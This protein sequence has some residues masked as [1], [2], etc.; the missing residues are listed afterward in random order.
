MLLYKLTNRVTGQSYIGVTGRPLAERLSNHRTFAAKGMN[1]PLAIA[2][3]KHGWQ[4]FEVSELGRA[5]SRDEVME[6]EKAAIV[7]YK[8]LA[9]NGYN[10][11][12]GGHGSPGP[13]SEATREKQRVSH[14]GQK[15]WIT[16]KRHSDESR[17]KMSASRKGNGWNARAITYEGVTYPS[18][19]ALCA[20]T[21]LTVGQVKARLF[22]GTA[23]H[24]APSKLVKGFGTWNK[25]KT[26]SPEA[27]QK[28]SAARKGR[29]TWNT[30][31]IEVDGVAYTSVEAC[32]QAT[33]LTRQNLKTRV[34]NGTARYLTAPNPV[35]AVVHFSEE[36]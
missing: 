29:P 21:G 17:A 6:M 1:Y 10:L 18:T 5:S 12:T 3:R 19:P 26:A 36:T 24:A 15:P 2:I 7:L 33:G 34:K 28:M 14:L 22:N 8:T 11:S 16:G 4:V 32:I 13:I 31:H 27:R 9:P 25:G 35:R 20:A 23:E 30:R